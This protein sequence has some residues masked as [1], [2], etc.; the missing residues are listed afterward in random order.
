VAEAHQ[1]LLLVLHALEEV[2][3]VLD[4]L[5]PVEH[6]QHGLVRPTVKRAVERGHAC[7]DGGVGIDLR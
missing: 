2:G 7:S 4:L 6:P 1:L 3:D 5:D